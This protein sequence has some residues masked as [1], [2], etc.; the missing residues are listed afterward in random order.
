[1]VVLR[2][3]FVLTRAHFS[4]GVL[5]PSGVRF[6][7][8]EIY[9]ALE[10]FSDR[11]DDS[12]C[13]GQRRPN[14]K[15]E[16]VLLFVKMRQGHSFTTTLEKQIRDRIRTSLSARHVPTYIFEV[17]DVPVSVDSSSMY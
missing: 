14:D 17:S 4:D 8:G 10:G 11:I 12:I 5:N 6:G 15:D 3:K 16:R 9:T 13:V 7:S 2:R 1:M